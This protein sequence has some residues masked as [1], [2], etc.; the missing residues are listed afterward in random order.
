M[1]RKSILTIITAVSVVLAFGVGRLSAGTPD[2]PGS[3]TSSAAQMHTLEQIYTRMISGTW[4]VT[5]TT[6][7]EPSTAPGTGTMHTLNDLWSV[8][9]PRALAKRVP[10][11]GQTSCWNAAGTVM[12]CSGTGQDGEYQMGITPAIPATGQTSGAYS[13]PSWTG[14]RFI[15]NGDGTVTDNLT[16]LTWLKNANCTETLGGVAKRAGHVKWMDALT[17]TN[18]L[19]S[20]NCGL[21]DGSTAG[22]WRLPNQNELRSLVDLTH[23]N[24]SVPAG[25][26]FT[27]VQPT[28][29][30]TS[31]TY[32]TVP[33][34]AC[35]ITFGDGGVGVS[36]KTMITYYVWPV[37][38]GE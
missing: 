14:V 5:M 34:N 4:A 22:Q 2:S 29:Y 30:W 17:W 36:D 23:S 24:P 21:A 13:V 19:A 37:R 25:H 27:N 7:T 1:R 35:Y 16:A 9:F 11:T 32:A 26:P 18:H 20:G 10:K 6:F 28:G 8:A 15:D 38:G 33:T 3:P 12:A 31:S